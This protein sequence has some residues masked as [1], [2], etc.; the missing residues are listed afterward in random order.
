MTLIADASS[1][2]LLSKTSI[3][4]DL[5]KNNKMI[6]PQ[7]VYE[8]VAKGKEKYREDAFIV[9]KL[10]EEKKIEIINPNLETKN[11]IKNLFGLFGGELDVLSLAV[12]KKFPI[13]TDDKKCLN[14]AKALEIKFTTSPQIAIALFK[15]NEINKQKALHALDSFEEFGWYKKEIIKFYREM[16]K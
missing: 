9:E 10:V 3:M 11:T 15:K 1:V 6:I 4:R 16:I 13:L 12:E 2:I 8:E 5:L 14:A 7:I